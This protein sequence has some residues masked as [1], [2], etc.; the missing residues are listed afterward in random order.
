MKQR[1]QQGNSS[2]NHY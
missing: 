2:F 1:K